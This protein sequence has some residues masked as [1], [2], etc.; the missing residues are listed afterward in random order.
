[1]TSAEAAKTFHDDQE[2]AKTFAKGD[3]GKGTG[4]DNT[5]K[6][7]LIEPLTIVSLETWRQVLKRNNVDPKGVDLN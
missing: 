4:N 1:V 2:A 7:T 5:G 6:A 3:K